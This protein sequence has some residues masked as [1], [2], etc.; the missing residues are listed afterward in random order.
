MVLSKNK[1]YKQ[2]ARKDQT[3]GGSSSRKNSSAEIVAVGKNPDTYEQRSAADVNEFEQQPGEIKFE[4][5]AAAAKPK[6]VDVAT[7]AQMDARIARKQENRLQ[8]KKMSEAKLRENT[9]EIN[10]LKDFP[11]KRKTAL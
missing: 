10:K 8:K 11:K 3:D 7:K 9:D 4:S 2:S 1:V 6:K 5:S